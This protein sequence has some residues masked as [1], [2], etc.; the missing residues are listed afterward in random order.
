M[1]DMSFL[2]CEIIAEALDGVIVQ[3]EGACRFLNRGEVAQAK[4]AMLRVAEFYRHAARQ[5][6]EMED[7]KPAAAVKEAA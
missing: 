6:N 2:H 3:A 1:I 5:M 7:A 4:A